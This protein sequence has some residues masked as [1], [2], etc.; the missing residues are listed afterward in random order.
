MKFALGLCALALTFL[1]S[2]GRPS[3]VAFIPNGNGVAGVAALGHVNAAG[4]GAT[5]AFGEAFGA[6]GHEW[7]KALCQADSDRDGATNGQE[8][9]DP[10]C[11]WTPSAGFDSSTAAQSPTHP[12]VANSFTTDQLA[13]MTCGGEA[14]LD[15]VS[16]SGDSSSPS[17][18]SASGSQTS[19]FGGRT[20]G[21]NLSGSLDDVVAPELQP[22]FSPG[23][24]LDQTSPA[25]ATSTAEQL[26]GSILAVCCFSMLAMA[27]A[28]AM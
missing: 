9:G 7:T 14:D 10:C 12:G 3:F 24:Q 11:T 4:G 16:S 25:P 19:S 6:A 27:M 21:S 23:P 22:R 26:K 17:S 5:N 8:L 18:L 20:T 28:M 15:S 13:A 2:A 1:Q